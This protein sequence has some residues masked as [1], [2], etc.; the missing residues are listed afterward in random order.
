MGVS[1]SGG[2][3]LHLRRSGAGPRDGGAPKPDPD[4]FRSSLAR[5]AAAAR[6][7][8]GD[9]EG[10]CALVSDLQRDA[11]FVPA[12][13]AVSAVSTAES[14]RSRS[15]TSILSAGADGAASAMGPGQPFG[16]APVNDGAP[17][18]GVS[19]LALHNAFA[20]RL[21]LSQASGETIVTFSD[22]RSAAR[23]AV[24][25]HAAN[26]E[27]SL[28]LSMNEPGA[29]RGNQASEELRRRLEARGLSIARIDMA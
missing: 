13:A 10:A 2:L 7:G 24:V 5:Q 14:A 6:D 23:E 19:D 8:M 26:G 22:M 9:G 1:V 25:I 15:E 20:E 16:P 4:R 11:L 3:D 29:D 27:L 18:R 17:G 28:S 12:E 21:A